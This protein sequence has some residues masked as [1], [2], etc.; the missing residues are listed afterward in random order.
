MALIHEQLYKSSSLAQINFKNY[1]NELVHYLRRSFTTQAAFSV[2]ISVT[3][4]ETDIEMDQA[5]PL[6]LL[7]SE[8]ISNSLKH[9][10]PSEQ[11]DG[12]GKIWITARREPPG[13]LI[14]SI[15]DNGVGIPENMDIEHSPTMG[16]QLIR[17]FVTQLQGELTIQRN[18]GTVF[19]ITIPERKD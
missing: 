17:S 7:V 8:L 16:L 6:G 3:V 14:V 19:T 9:A 12:T 1:I 18:P 11:P 5:V 13:S 2:E 15:G 10:F 4:E